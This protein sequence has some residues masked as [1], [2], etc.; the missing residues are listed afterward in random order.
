MNRSIKTLSDLTVYSK[1]SKYDKTKKRR[2][3][4]E[5]ICYRNRDMHL[6]KYPQLRTEIL[7]VYNNFLK[8]I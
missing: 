7:N 2:E 8:E 6:K 3:T 1:Y 4:W 5:E